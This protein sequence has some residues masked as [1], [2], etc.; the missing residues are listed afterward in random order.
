[1]LKQFR[2]LAVSV[3]LL[4]QAQAPPPPPPLPAL[5]PAVQYSTGPIDAAD[6]AALLK[7]H[8]VPGVSVAVIRDFK[9]EWARGYGIADAEAGTPVTTDTMFQAASISKPVAAMVSMKAVQDGRFTLDQDVNTILKSWKLPGGEFTRDRPVTPRGLMSHTSGMGD[10][11]GFP[12][13]APKAPLP[14]VPQ[15]LDGQRP[16]PQPPVRLERPPSTGFKYSGGAVMVQE[17]ALTEAVGRPL[18]ELARDWVLNPIGMT[19]STFEQP[20]PAS[21]EKQAARAHG[22]LG[23]RMGDPWHVYPERAAAG[24]W[25]TPTDL[26]KFL[27]EAQQT[28]AGASTRVLS[29][30][31]MLEMVTPVGVGPYAVGFSVEKQGEGWYF[32]HNGANW[33]FHGSMS[34]H[35][36]KGYGLVIMTNGDGGP[37][38]MRELRS[39]IQQA[40]QW[41][42]LDKPIPRTYGPVK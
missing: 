37:G 8:N 34:A 25:T 9:I 6:M 27:I 3:T 1:M 2:L 31:M 38:L 40:Y 36:L 18:V 5:T 21:R 26:A 22:R 15:I 11:F 16:S 14:T 20:L 42:V 19:N 32:G 41:D 28:L 33:G 10:G 29:R 35:R 30:A 12:G 24:L 7:Q 39:R 13:Y 23:G 17:L 4:G